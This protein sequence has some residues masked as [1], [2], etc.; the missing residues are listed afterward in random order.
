MPATS[1]AADPSDA[2]GVDFDDGD[3]DWDDKS[4]HNYVRCVRPGV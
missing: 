3:D 2:W 4:D 1:D